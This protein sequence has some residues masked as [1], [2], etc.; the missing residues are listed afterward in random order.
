MYSSLKTDHQECF[1][2]SAKD[3]HPAELKQLSATPRALTLLK[4]CFKTY[5]SEELESESLTC[6]AEA[7]SMLAMHSVCRLQTIYRKTRE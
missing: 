5:V 2:R 4:R 1:F 6:M 7:C 3:L